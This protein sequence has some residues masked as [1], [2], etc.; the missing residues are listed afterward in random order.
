MLLIVNCGKEQD[1]VPNVNVDIYISLSDPNFIDLNPVGGW[2]YITGGSRGIIVYK[3]ST[4][5][6]MAYDRHCTYLPSN[7][8]ARV[9][10]DKSQ[11][12]AVDSCCGSKFLLT[13]G[14][15]IGPPATIPLK[16]FSTTFDGN[17]VHIYN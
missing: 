16:S 11:I 15:V 13:D 8:C 9:E 10:V 14:S 2:V 7:S 17:T 6:F 4:T 1:I 12:M 3:K 5:E